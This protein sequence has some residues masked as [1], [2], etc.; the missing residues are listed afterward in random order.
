VFVLHVLL[1]LDYLVRIQILLWSAVLCKHER[2]GL[3]DC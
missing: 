3:Y 1:F 2:M